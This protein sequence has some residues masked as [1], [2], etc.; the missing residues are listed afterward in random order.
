MSLTVSGMLSGLVR[1]VRNEKTRQGMPFR[2]RLLLQ[3]AK[4][5]VLHSTAS[6]LAC[7]ITA[8]LL[9]RLF[10]LEQ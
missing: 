7:N 6:I 4:A 3:F 2:S 8:V 10:R 9:T 5:F 1:E